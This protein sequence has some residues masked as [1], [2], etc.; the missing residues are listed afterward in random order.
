MDSPSSRALLL[1]SVLQTGRAWSASELARHFDIADRTVRRDIARLRS[2][3]YHIHSTPGP[4]GA[5]RLIPGV[6]IPPLL[7]DAD[8]VCSLVTGLL[9]LE[10]GSANPTTTA[11]R[12]KLEQ[13]LPPSLR[14]RA[15]A[16]GLATQIITPS[17]GPAD[18]ALLGTLAEAVAEGQHLQFT[19]TDQ[20]GRVSRRQVR[21]HRHILR[22]SLW[23]LVAFDTQQEDWRLFRIDRMQGAVPQEAPRASQVP[24]FPHPSIEKWLTSDFGRHQP[25]CE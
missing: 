15:A 7:L 9:V 25:P 6:K 16:T 24:D 4:H 19:Y 22:Q 21:P 14:R 3:G 2:L 11:V 8:E 20:A 12:A 23:Y 1:L 17:S 13:L 5:Y 10:A 18:W